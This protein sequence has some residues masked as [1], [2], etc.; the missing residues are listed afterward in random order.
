[1]S[2]QFVSETLQAARGRWLHILPVLGITVPE[3]GKHGA[4]PKCGGSDRF[5][6]DDQEGR[7]TWICS[8]CSHGDGLDLIRLVSGN[9]AFQAAT[10]VAKALALPNAPQEA[11]KPARNEIPEERKKAM[12]AKAY[13]ALLA[14]CSSGESSYLADKGL[15]GHSQSIT[16]DVHKTGGMDFPAGSLLLP[17]TDIDG[18]LTG[19][20]LISPLGDKRL[21]PNTVLKGAFIVVHPLEAGDNP[22]LVV[23]TEGYATA[24]TLDMLTDGLVVAAVAANNLPNV[25][26]H[27]RHKW[28]D[29]RLII[30]GDNDFDDGK[31]NTGKQWAEKAAKAVDGWV[32]L[33]PTRHKAD[34]DDYRRDNGLERA[35]EAFREEMILFGKGKT[36]LP[37][38]FRLTQEYLWYDKLV[39][40]SDGDTE[41]RNIKLCSPVRVTAITCDSDGGN[42]GR[43]LEWEDTN[44]ISRKWAM[45]MEM[46]SSSGEELRRILLSNGLSY[47]STTGQARAHLMEYL[48]L[49]KPERKVTCVN[50]TGW[51]GSVYVLQDEVIGVGAESVILQTASVQGRDFRTAGT[52]DEWRDQISRYCVGN[53]RVAFSVSLSFA[54]PLLKLV[55]VGGGGYHLKGE[56]TDGKTTTMK[57]AASVCGGTDFW[58]TWRSTGN[59]LEGTASRRNDATLMLDEIR[60]VDGREAGNIAYML[61]NGQGKARARTDGSLREA[62]RWCLLFLSTGELSLVEHAANAGERTYAGVEVRMVQ[63]P[64]DSGKHGVFEELHGFAGGKA[65]SEHLEQAVAS[66]YGEPFRAWLRLLT[67]DLTGMTSKAKILLKE[68]TR[69]LT[70]ENAGN[71]VGRA[72]TRF[73]LV[74]MAGELATQVGITGWPEGEAF[75]AAQT[76]LNAWMGDRGHTANQEDAAALEQVKEFI[77]RNQFSRFADWHDERSRPANMVGFRRVD[78]GN[79]KE[80]A[81]TTFFIL[82]TGWKEICKGFDAKKVAQL[83]VKAGYLDVPEDARTQ[84][85]IRLPEMGLK[86]VYQ[87]NSTVLG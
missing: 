58:H 65:L 23:I 76:C 73:A 33:P 78:K 75:R 41:I 50:K 86:R 24:L 6:F 51:H 34:W 37:Q 56:S 52:L 55:G 7:G 40:K 26:Q 53:G 59:A 47:I 81:V 66:C 62:N 29:A 83:C 8:Q 57:V 2:N 42:Y 35:K 49:C 38:G 17:L 61:A 32:S 80:D 39:N 72:V 71:Q 36:K 82:A 12:V 64:S 45:P 3:N 85:N 21:L 10:E 67:A 31:E 48:S 14:S 20:Q 25:A 1:M 4:C 18:K 16:Q 5:R 30:A 69:L 13:H 44:G 68:Y 60:E 46:L 22:E 11:I 15:S 63:I 28:P 74:A 54:S 84:K 27:L 79:N 43:L 9:G 19:G 70:P 87:F 77:T